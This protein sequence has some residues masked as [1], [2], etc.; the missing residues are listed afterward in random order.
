MRTGPSIQ[1]GWAVT[2]SGQDDVSCVYAF[3]AGAF[4]RGRVKLEIESAA[5]DYGEVEVRILEDRGWLASEFRVHLS[6][7]R[8]SVLELRRAINKW[9]RAY[10]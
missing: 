3:S 1:G 2:V 4:V 9:V 7:P 5:L 6:G 8:A 10:E